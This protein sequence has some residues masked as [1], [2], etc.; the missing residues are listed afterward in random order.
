MSDLELYLSFV[1]SFKKKIEQIAI[2]KERCRQEEY[3]RE[4][5]STEF[6]LEVGKWYLSKGYEVRV[7]KPSKDGGVDIVLTKD[8]KLTFVQCKHYKKKVDVTACRELVGVMHTKN[9]KRGEIVALNGVTNEAKIFCG[10]AGIKIVTL[11][12]LIKSN[13]ENQ[14]RVL[15]SLQKPTLPFRSNLPTPY[16]EREVY[17][18]YIYGN[19]FQDFE[20]AAEEIEKIP[21]ANLTNL[22]DTKAIVKY[23][24]RF[25]IIYSSLEK[26]KWLGNYILRYVD[27]QSGQFVSP[28]RLQ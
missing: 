12:T 7:T 2:K 3:W 21:I 22:F 1:D 18:Y 17:G 9:V 4:L 27:A 8:D 14:Q 20:Q 19:I 15:R 5:Q 28:R 10:D 11:R 16:E 25:F 13:K 26:I 24:D 6:E 23:Q